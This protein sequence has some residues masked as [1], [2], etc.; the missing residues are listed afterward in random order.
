MT[1]ELHVISWNCEKTSFVRVQ[2]TCTCNH[3]LVKCNWFW[4]TS[5]AP[6]CGHC[7]QLAPIWDQLGEKYKD[8]ESIVV[9][10]M[11]STANELEDVK[12]QSFPTIKFF[13]KGSNEV[14]VL[15]NFSIYFATAFFVSCDKVIKINVK[16][17]CAYFTG[18]RLQWWKNAGRLF[19]V[20]RQ[21]W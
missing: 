5:D 11:D 18:S 17:N 10:K 12:I 20:F 19:K 6:W 2:F 13:P 7:K 4:L 9:A 15:C 3:I 1:V 16:S 21:W 8:D 14:I